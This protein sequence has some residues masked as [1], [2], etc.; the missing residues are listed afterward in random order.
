[1]AIFSQNGTRLASHQV[2]FSCWLDAVFTARCSEYCSQRCDFQRREGRTARAHHAA[3][4]SPSSTC[5]QLAASPR[6][7]KCQRAAPL[8]RRTLQHVSANI[9]R[10]HDRDSSEHRNSRPTH[11]GIDCVT[12]FS[13]CVCTLSVVPASYS[14]CVLRIVVLV[15]S[16]RSATLFAL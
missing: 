6:C 3:P 8:N 14:N 9:S 15:H 12:F 5:S 2:L 16:T 7:A 4:I 10:Q 1:M 11:V 13:V